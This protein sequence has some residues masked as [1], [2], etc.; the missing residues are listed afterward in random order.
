M[1]IQSLI[2]QRI[3]AFNNACLAM[4]RRDP[5]EYA[6]QLWRVQRLDRIIIKRQREA[7]S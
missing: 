7:T 5:H 1:T 4:R 3:S 2:A 6:A